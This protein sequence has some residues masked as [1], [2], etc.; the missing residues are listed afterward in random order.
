MSRETIAVILAAGEGTRMKSATPKVLHEMAHRSM[1]AHVLAAVECAGIRHVA[2]IVG[3]DR[4]D[5][6]A[7]ARRCYPGADVFVQHERRGTG[8]AVLQAR[9]R[10][11][12]D[13]DTIVLYGDT[14]LITSDAILALKTSL[15]EGSSVSVL[16]FEANDPTGYGRLVLEDGELVRITEERDADDETRRIRFVNGG[17]M[18]LAGPT[19]VS[20]LDSIED[21]N[22]KREFYITDAV[23]IARARGLTARAVPVSE[24]TV[25][26]VNDRVQLAAAEAVMQRRLR[27]RIMREGATLTA[28][29]TVFFAFDTKVGRDVLIEPHCVF[30][31]GVSIDDG[32]V[33]HAFSHLEGASVGKGATVGPYARLRPGSDIGPK[34]KVGNFV[35]TKAALVEAG[36]KINH[37]SYIGDARV[38]P[39]ANIG[40]GTITCNY[41]G[42]LKYKTDIGAGAFIG[43]NSS[44]VAPVSIGDGGYVGSGSVI[45][46]DV[47]GDALAV[48]RGQQVTK[49]GWAASF[50]ARMAARK[51]A[52]AKG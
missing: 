14:P 29:E 50:R 39:D 12:S 3:P 18:A 36:A 20:L 10:I 41:D 23:A 27:E 40:A 35:E 45:T 11:R 43:S 17:L 37:L 19:A 31:R 46:K 49:A 9:D 7:E 44:L 24:E 8:H 16:G 28:P 1:L 51:A 26:G 47:P 42:F 52:K 4:D 34:A 22:T 13:L 6:A 32:A 38:G 15:N 21:N 30:G 2:V 25:Q 33:I 5:V 48:A